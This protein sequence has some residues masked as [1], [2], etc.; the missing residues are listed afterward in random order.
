MGY[1]SSAL[2]VCQTEFDPFGVQICER[3]RSSRALHHDRNGD[4]VSRPPEPLLIRRNLQIAP[5]DLLAV[6]RQQDH[7]QL[8]ISPRNANTAVA[9]SLCHESDVAFKY[10]GTQQI[11]RATNDPASP[12]CCSLRLSYRGSHRLAVPLSVTNRNSFQDVPSGCVVDPRSG[13]ARF[14]HVVGMASIKK[15]SPQLGAV[16]LLSFLLLHPFYVF[17]PFGI[18]PNGVT[19]FDKQRNI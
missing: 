11:V 6:G 5:V 7:R 4:E 1:G 18:H 12:F 16:F 3:C 14:N 8:R 19:F 15:H 13:S 17:F 2:T 9:A 10:K